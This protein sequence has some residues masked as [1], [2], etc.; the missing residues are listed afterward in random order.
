MIL[1]KYI[2]DF[3]YFVPIAFIGWIKVLFHFLAYLYSVWQKN[4]VM[5]KISIVVFFFQLFFSTRPWFEYQIRFNEVDET[6][7]V[8]SKVNLIFIFISLVNFILLL[9]EFSFSTILI[10]ILQAITGVLFLFGYHSPTALHI[11]FINSSDYKFHYNFYSFALAYSLALFLSI[12][13]FVKK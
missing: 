1:V 8:S 5:T 4:A 7:L 13:S 2:R 10:L 11:D 6:L 3:F 9:G 12:Q